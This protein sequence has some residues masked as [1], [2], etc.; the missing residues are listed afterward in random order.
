[1]ILDTKIKGLPVQIKI[2]N[3]S[4]R[5]RS[6]FRVYMKIHENQGKITTFRENKDI[7]YRKNKHH[8]TKGSMK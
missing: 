4:F 5:S 8:I 6:C 3:R 1:M 2:G 7:S